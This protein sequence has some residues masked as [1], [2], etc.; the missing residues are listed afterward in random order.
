MVIGGDW[1]RPARASWLVLSNF[2]VLV[3]SLDRVM[4]I[5]MGLVV[6]WACGSLPAEKLMLP[7]V[8]SMVLARMVAFSQIGPGEMLVIWVVWGSKVKL[9]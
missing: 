1:F 9:S 8:A 2:R 6:C 3:L 4:V 7:V 5:R